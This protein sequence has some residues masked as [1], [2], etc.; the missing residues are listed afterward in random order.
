[1]KR[2]FAASHVIPEIFVSDASW[3]Y[4]KSKTA[5]IAAA[6][7]VIREYG[8]RA[9]TLNNIA[10]KAGITEP[11][12]FRHFE[13]VDGLFGALFK[14]YERVYQRSASAFAAE[15]KGLA[16]L[17]RA[18]RE[19]VGNIEASRDFSYVLLNARHVFRAYPALR[20]KV[21][22][23]DSRD[24]GAVLACISEGVKSGDVRSDIDP[25]SAASSLIGG[26][27]IAAFMWIESGFGFDLRAVFED[28]WDDFERMIATKPRPKSPEARAA[29]K[30]RSVAYF[31]LRPASPARRAGIASKGKP[32]R[33]AAPGAK[34]GNRDGPVGV[35]R[36]R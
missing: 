23:N 2:E 17:R 12:I 14:A 24:H 25:V 36:K 11:A 26:I 3:P 4:S 22:D 33:K 1:M 9:A 29:A 13:G 30:R 5:V 6:S 34:A 19:L 7:A 27:Y 10:L 15:G 16:K 32:G 35:G 28:R 21:A 31:P 8:P 18:S 20:A